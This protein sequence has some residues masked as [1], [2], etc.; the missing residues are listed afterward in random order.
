M[1]LH[2]TVFVA[3][4]DPSRHLQQVCRHWSHILAVEF[5]SHQAVVV[6]PRNARGADWPGN[7]TLKLEAGAR[8]LECRLTASARDQLEVL[9]TVVARH[10]DRFALRAGPVR[11]EWR[12]RH[13]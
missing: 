1:S 11:Y 5:T 9:K 2:S 6:F 3:T 10:L 12:D 13:E 8:T 4:D 7:A